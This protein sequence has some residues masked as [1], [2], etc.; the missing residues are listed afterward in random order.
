MQSS[1][2]AVWRHLQRLKSM[3]VSELYR[4]LDPWI[5]LPISFGSPRRHRLFSPL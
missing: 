4:V 5:S 3:S 2:G 1:Q